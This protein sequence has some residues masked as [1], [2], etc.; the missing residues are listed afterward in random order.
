M[1]CVISLKAFV[2]CYTGRVIIHLYTYG[3]KLLITDTP[4]HHAFVE[5]F[6]LS[7][8]V[9]DDPPYRIVEFQTLPPSLVKLNEHEQITLTF[10]LKGNYELDSV[11]MRKDP[12]SS[13]KDWVFFFF[14]RQGG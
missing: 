13:K 3:K 4:K 8:E 10:T 9:D 12:S 1:S 7:P 6:I 2:I 5:K 11:R 14:K